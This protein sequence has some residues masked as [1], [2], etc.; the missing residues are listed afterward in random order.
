M[1]TSC[2]LD[3]AISAVLAAKE[4]ATRTEIQFTVAAKQLDA[5]QQQ[6]EAVNQLLAQAAQLS[7]SLTTGKSFDGVG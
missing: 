7:K 3:P 6:G 4:Q 5:A 2:S 1:C